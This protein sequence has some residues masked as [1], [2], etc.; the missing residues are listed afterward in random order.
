MVD[1]PKCFRGRN[2]DSLVK[3]KALFKRS[4][5]LLFG[6]FIMAF[7]VALSVKANLGTTPISSVPYVFS[8]G[9]PFTMGETT[10]VINA[11]LIV[12]QIALLRR[13]FQPI[14]LL[15]FPIV[16]V[17][18]LF[19]DFTLFLV[20][21][22]TPLSNYPLQL[23]VCLLSILIVA[24]GVFLE[25]KAKLIYLAG[26]GLVLAISKS[27]HQEFGKVKIGFD[28]ALVLLAIVSSL[29]MLDD[30]QGVREGTVAS[31]LLV[32]I[33]ARF[34]A[35]KI[36]FVDAI[37]GAKPA[38]AV[39]IGG[40]GGI[41]RAGTFTLVIAR[42]FGSGGHEIGEIIARKLGV[43]F[44]DKDLIALS[45]AEGGLT[46][47]YVK[48]HEQ[49][50]D[51]ELLYDLYEQN[52]AYVDGEVPPLDALFLAQSKVIREISQRESCVIVGRCADF[53]LIDQ[54]NCFT[55][56]VHA[57]KDYRTRRIVAEYGID[58][59]AAIKALERTDRNRANYYRHYTNKLW[60]MA[61]N[62][63][64]SIDSALFGPE[65]TA[66]LIIDAMHAR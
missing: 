36:K 51:N 31:A 4:A 58:S 15:Q 57:G 39:E 14:Q 64:M 22:K 59:N 12:L 10:I 27:F 16:A 66:S 6:L 50:L 52:Y 56:F 62:Y 47:E 33:V 60:G 1:H 53:V 35:K 37:I 23:A 65:K 9:L 38:K 55:V 8:L 30:V 61:C 25:V 40:I 21:A 63:H 32:G 49:Q 45:A 7:G 46:A 29:L 20:S 3:T 44:Y 18:G 28:S 13:E 26:E 41:D 34:Y 2:E 24:F 54:K 5:I 42:E 43:S 17:F 19:T 48:E 11:L